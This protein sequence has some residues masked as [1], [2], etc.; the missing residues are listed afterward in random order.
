M[1]QQRVMKKVPSTVS[2]MSSN[3]ECIGLEQ[4]P[5]SNGRRDHQLIRKEN[6]KGTI[7]EKV[8]KQDRMKKTRWDEYNSKLQ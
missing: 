5:G 4:I 3:S 8:K 2:S 7:R 1:E 6:K